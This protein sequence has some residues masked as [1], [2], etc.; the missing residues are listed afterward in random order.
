MKTQAL[1]I[2]FIFQR[3][4]IKHKLKI[5]CRKLAISFLAY[6]ARV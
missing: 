5:A 3:D 1:N 2:N 6:K 4:F